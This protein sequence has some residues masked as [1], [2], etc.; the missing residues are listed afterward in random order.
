M[1]LCLW[2][3][4]NLKVEVVLIVTEVHAFTIDHYLHLCVVLHFTFDVLCVG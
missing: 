1:F 2:C 4:L 3:R